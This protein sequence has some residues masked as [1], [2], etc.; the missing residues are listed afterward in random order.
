MGLTK[1]NIIPKM[2]SDEFPQEY[3]EL[4]NRAEMGLEDPVDGVY[5]HEKFK[6]MYDTF[7]K[8]NVNSSD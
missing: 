4:V 3:F 6:E 2:Y 5:Q 7:V 8:R 1:I